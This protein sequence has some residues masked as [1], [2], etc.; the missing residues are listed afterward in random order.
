MI[1]ITDKGYE[2]LSAFVPSEVQDLETLMAETGFA[3]RER[4]KSSSSVSR[5]R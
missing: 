1:L 2:N 3:E 4:R 5:Q